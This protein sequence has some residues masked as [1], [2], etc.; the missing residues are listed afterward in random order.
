MGLWSSLRLYLSWLLKSKVR[1]GSWVG[2]F[3]YFLPPPPLE[4]LLVVVCP[5][6][7][8]YVEL[9]DPEL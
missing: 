3:F 6:G 9:P 5:D 7:D 4:L 8:V 1:G 2:H